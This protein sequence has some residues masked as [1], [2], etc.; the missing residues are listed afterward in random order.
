MVWVTRNFR[1]AVKPLVIILVIAF[2]G[3][4]LFTGG[5]YLFGRNDQTVAAIGTVNGQPISGMEFQQLYYNQLQSAQ[6]E[7]GRLNNQIIESVKYGTFEHLVSEALQKQEIEKRKITVAKKEI[8]EELSKLKEIYSEDIL[9]QLGYTDAALRIIIEEQLKKDKLRAEIAGPVDITEQQIKDFYEQ[10]EASHIL[11]R[12]ESDNEEAWAKARERGEFVLAQLAEMDFAEA[13]KQYSDDSNA[14]NGGQ[15]GY[16]GRGVMVPQFENT[17]FNLEVGEISDLVRTEYGYHIIKVTDKYVAEGEEFEEI[18]EHIRDYLASQ[19]QDKLFQP[20][21]EEQRANADL[22]IHD[23]QITAFGH[24]LNGDLEKAIEFYNK[25]IESGSED[26]YIYASL[27][28]VYAELGDYEQAAANFE[29]AVN[30]ITTD[31]DLYFRLGLA[32]EELDRIDAAVD[33]Y[34]KTSELMAYDLSAQFLVLSFLNDLGDEEA[35]KIV[36][37]R[38]EELYSMYEQ[39]ESADTEVEQE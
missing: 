16:F 13:A 19:E 18:K 2:V 25:A 10:V 34:L 39:L 23:H 36:E 9:E 32:Y 8:D 7:Y 28:D 17:A 31:G 20:W 22:V 38:L 4:T 11:I 12:V 29:L 3:G 26:G 35:I 37:N 14:A 15:L 33:A 6:M 5:A 21:L 1:K 24:R 27:G 30:K